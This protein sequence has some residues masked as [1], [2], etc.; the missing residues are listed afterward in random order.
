[1]KTNLRI[2]K[3]FFRNIRG[4]RCVSECFSARVS[5]DFVF[6]LTAS[7]TFSL[8]HYFLNV[9]H[10]VHGVKT[11]CNANSTVQLLIGPPLRRPILKSGLH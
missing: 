10:H 5:V 11:V 8:R 9:W 1:M 4:L 2:K 6:L 3:L 7:R